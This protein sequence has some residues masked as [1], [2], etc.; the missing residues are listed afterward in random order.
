MMASLEERN[1][2]E[3][4]IIIVT[5]DNGMAFPGAKTNLYE[6]GL[7]VPL[8]IRWG[9][10][11]D[12]KGRAVDDLVSLTDIAPTLL[13]SAGVS[14]PQEMTGKSLTKIFRSN[15]SGLIDGRRKYVFAGK[16][17]HTVC[18]EDDLSY[19]QR[20]VRDHSFLYIRN[21]EADRWPA[22][23]PDVISSHGYVYG[24]IDSSPTKSYLIAHQ[25][26]GEISELFDF[27]MAKRPFE[28]LYDIVNDPSC[29]NNLIAVDRFVKDKNRLKKILDE[30][31]IDTDDP[32]AVT[33][34]S[35]WDGFPYYFENPYGIIPYH[36]VNNR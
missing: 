4:T 12:G 15:K 7:H 24:D 27:A 16:E 3:N 29:Q 9:N 23:A 32:R 35:A 34:K 21:I 1:L 5:S 20:S 30:Y 28:E 18:L 10:G 11:I 19:P 6:Y 13:Q 17:R 22:G 25:T 26:E 36:E 2:L 14:V 33:G 31:L 8:A